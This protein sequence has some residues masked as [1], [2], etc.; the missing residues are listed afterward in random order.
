MIACNTIRNGSCRRDKKNIKTNARIYARLFAMG[1]D[2]LRQR[3]RRLGPG[4]VTG[5]SD[6]DPSG[7]ATYMQAGAAFGLGL[8]WTMLLT[9]PFLI[10]IQEA[11]ARLALVTKH[12]YIKNLKG[13]IWRPLLWVGALL[14]VC[15]NAFN[16]GADLEF[17]AASANLLY[18]MPTWVW[19]IVFV[20]ATLC[21]QIFLT[22]KQYAKYLKWLCLFLLAYV[23]VAFTIKIDWSAVAIATF[24]PSFQ[25]TPEFGLLFAVLGTTIS[26]YLM[27]W[28]AAQEV[29]QD[30]E[31]KAE[32]FGIDDELYERRVDVGLGMVVSNVVAWFIIV[33][34][35]FVL[36]VNGIHN[37]SSPAEAAMVL[38]PIAGPY[39]A[40]LFTLGIVGTGLLA[41]PILSG[42]SAYV[43]S[44]M[45][46]LKQSG[47]SKTWKQ[48]PVF[49]GIV[50]AVTIA[51]VLSASWGLNPVRALIYAALGNAFLAPILILSIIRLTNDKKLMGR[52][53]N[54]RLSNLLLWSTF[55]LMSF[56]L[57]MWFYLER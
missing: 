39:A 37:V 42:S 7:I 25:F 33:T 47:L 21:L 51:G 1:F 23:A 10:A 8:L 35:A 15:V 4:L 12:G 50:I 5:A 30:N 34:A 22:Y 27:V 19:L 32:H 16:L 26:P 9:I 24:V 14:F 38:A 40:L 52:Y 11:S 29:E 45:L 44:A 36:F 54:N 41:V 18:P 17:M 31:D 13:R 57:G 49:Y 6:D 55:F 28:Q 3:F 56:A 43:I 48:A 2:A 53:V 20:V 46:D